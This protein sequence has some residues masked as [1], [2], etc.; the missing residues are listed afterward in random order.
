MLNSITEVAR[1]AS[2]LL[3]IAPFPAWDDRRAPTITFT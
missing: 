2:A 3:P 1:A